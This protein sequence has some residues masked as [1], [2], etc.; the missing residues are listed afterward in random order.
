MRYRMG[1]RGFAALGVAAMI[2]W[3]AGVSFVIWSILQIIE[4]GRAAVGI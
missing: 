2:A 1:D 4:I 3:V